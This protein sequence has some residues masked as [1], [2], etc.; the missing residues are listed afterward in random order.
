VASAR[1]SLVGV[2]R[3]GTAYRSL[4]AHVVET[5]NEVPSRIGLTKELLNFRLELEEPEYCIVGRTG[6]S[7]RF[8]HEEILQILAGV[9][10]NERLRAIT[11]KAA[12]LITLATAYGPRTWEQ[13]A[14]CASELTSHP[15]SRRAVVYIGRPE[16]AVSIGEATAGEMP[17]TE[18]WQFHLRDDEL[19]MTVTM[20]SW[21]LV[22]GLSYDIPSFV[23][24][25][26]A[27]AHSLGAGLGTYVHTAGSGHIYEQHFGIKT[28]QVFEPLDISYVLSGHIKDTQNKARTLLKKELTH[29]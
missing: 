22:W 15:S 19:H 17:C 29:A 9:H 2:K 8:M 11:P 10:D 16:D 28:T 25:Q 20:R 4:L 7:E 26:M 3:L 6:M 27:V 24:V 5:G 12:D 14:W 13:V 21:D 18:T 1:D 23:A